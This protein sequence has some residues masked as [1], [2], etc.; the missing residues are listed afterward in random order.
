MPQN[1]IRALP[2]YH[3]ESLPIPPLQVGLAPLAALSSNDC[4]W[5]TLLLW[6]SNDVCSSSNS[7]RI[8]KQSPVPGPRGVWRSAG[9]PRHGFLA[10]WH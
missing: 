10:A 6:F 4:L 9:Y 7:W 5:F 2:L 8:M 3:T 1:P